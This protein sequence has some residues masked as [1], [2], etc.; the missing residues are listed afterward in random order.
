MKLLRW[1]LEPFKTD[2]RSRTALELHRIL[3]MCAA[4]QLTGTGCILHL[5]V[6]PYSV[7]TVYIQCTM[8]I[9]HTVYTVHPA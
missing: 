9:L 3:E 8:Y 7:H 2:D 1:S 4:C 6:V 5:I